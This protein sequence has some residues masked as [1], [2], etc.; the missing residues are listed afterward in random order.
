MQLNPTYM[1]RILHFK[2][3]TL[4]SSYNCFKID[5]HQ[6]LIVCLSTRSWSGVNSGK[7]KRSCFQNLLLIKYGSILDTLSRELPGTRPLS[8]VF[9]KLFEVVLFQTL[10]CK[11]CPSQG[12]DDTIFTKSV[13]LVS[14]IPIKSLLVSNLLPSIYEI[15]FNKFHIKPSE[16]ALYHISNYQAIASHKATNTTSLYKLMF[17]F[18]Y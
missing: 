11:G 8:K 13:N 5:I 18:K 2:N 4:K 6:K 1:K 16:C 3:I 12:L 17:T 14:N 15:F 10:N 9:M 7:F